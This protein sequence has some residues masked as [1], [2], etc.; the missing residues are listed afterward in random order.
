M[1]A[2]IWTSTFISLGKVLGPK[3]KE[4][5]GSIRKYLI[6]GGIIATLILAGI[7]LYRNYK[8]HILETMKTTLDQAVKTFRSLRR[9]K[10]LVVGT[11]AIFLGLFVLMVGL[12]Q[13]Y[14]A[15]EFVQFDAIARFLVQAIF[16]V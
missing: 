8:Q 6:I 3:W 2:F 1:G 7:Y 9:V 13:D 14:L 11:A 5:H 15:N 4:F 16:A 12:I 10:V